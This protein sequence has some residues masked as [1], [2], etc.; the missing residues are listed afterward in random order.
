MTSTRPDLRLTVPVDAAALV[1]GPGRSLASYLLLPRPKDAVKGLVLPLVFALGVLA[2]GGTD[3]RALWRALLVWAAVELLVYQARYQWNDVRGFA[4]DQGHPDSASRGRLPGPLSAARRSVTSSCAVALLRLAAVAALVLLL[5]GLQLGGVLLSATAGVLGVAVVYEVL[6][7]LGTGRT[8]AVPVPLRPAL[9]AL[10]VVVGA[11]YAVRAVTG[12]ALAVDLAGRPAL[13]VAAV[14]S[15]WAVGVAFVTSRWA[16]E[17]MSFARLQG[18]AVQWRATR[19]QAREHTLALVR[20]L[21]ATVDAR[22][23]AAGTGLAEWRALHRGTVLRAPWNLA[24]V[25]AGGAAAVTG[26]LLVGGT[27]PAGA[28]VALT[29]IAAA[30]VVV[31]A[32]RSR[33]PTALALAAALGA[34]HL[35][36]GTSRPAL[37]VLPWLVALLSVTSFLAQSASSVGHPLRRVA[38]VLGPLCGLLAP[39]GRLVIGPRTWNAVCSPSSGPRA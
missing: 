34:V 27:G 13:A 33:A 20:W 17:A 39:A 24:A 35:A 18:V 14:L 12:L 16:L 30:V 23:L 8:D 15:A 25:T 10:W 28:V 32:R 31:R 36:L 6:R 26:W 19:E 1:G 2:T 3:G 37:A 38:P 4:A 21:P 5:P 11:G 29:G 7:T 22:D 9:V